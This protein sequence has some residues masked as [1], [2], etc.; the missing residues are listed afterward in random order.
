MP[1]RVDPVSGFRANYASG[2]VRPATAHCQADEDDRSAGVRATCAIVAVASA[3]Q[4][5]ASKLKPAQ[6]ELH[7]RVEEG[8]REGTAPSLASGRLASG[9]ECAFQPVRYRLGQPSP[10]APIERYSR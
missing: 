1:P 2:I 9:I 7:R 4:P 6:I 10:A 8:D 3:I 5:R